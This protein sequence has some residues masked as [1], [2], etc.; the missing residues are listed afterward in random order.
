[1]H[2]LCKLYARMCNGGMSY[3]TV[4]HTNQEGIDKVNTLWPKIIGCVNCHSSLKV[5]KGDIDSVYYHEYGERG[6]GRLIYVCICPCCDLPTD[7]G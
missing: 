7:F 3:P 5:D 1:M 6:Q 2:L 4:Y